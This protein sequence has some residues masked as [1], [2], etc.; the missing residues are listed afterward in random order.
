MIK[1]EDTF[2]VHS[3]VDI[4]I[5]GSDEVCSICDVI[6]PWWR[7]VGRS[8]HLTEC[9]SV[10]AE[11]ENTYETNFTQ[12][13]RNANPPSESPQVIQHL[14]K[15][16]TYIEHALTG[17][18]RRDEIHLG[19]VYCGSITMPGQFK[20]MYFSL[21]SNNFPFSL[22]N[23]VRELAQKNMCLSNSRMEITVR[24]FSEQI[25]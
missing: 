20:K 16:L 10:D 22:I 18:I 3:D 17:N 23:L 8:K 5:S 11:S 19:D 24:K 9:T 1:D 4:I 21:Q 13:I 25:F 14:P 7:E 6:Q 2:W 15:W 12:F